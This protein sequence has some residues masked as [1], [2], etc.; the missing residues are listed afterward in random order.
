MKSIMPELIGNR[1]LAA[2]IGQEIIS[3][4]LS[5]AYIIGGAKGSGRHTLANLIAASLACENKDRDDLPLPC[6]RC[7]HCRKIFSKISP[8]VI[9]YGLEDKAS[10]GVETVRRLRTDI[11][12]PP[13]DLHVKVYIIEDAD[14]M[15]HQAQNA[16][17][18]TLEEPPQYVL[19]LLLCERPEDMLETVRSRAPIL[20]TE[21][22]SAEEIEKY[23]VGDEAI[24]SLRK[25]SPNEFFEIVMASDGRIGKALELASPEHRSEILAA[26]AHA[27]NFIEAVAGRP[28]ASTLISLV[29][30][31]PKARADISVRINLIT[32]A[33]RDLIVLKRSE[34]A[35]L[36]FYHDRDAAID[37]SDR[38]TLSGLLSLYRACED[39]RKAILKNSNVKLTLT[40]LVI[41]GNHGK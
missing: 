8:D 10:I 13:N 3:G 40:N 15:T 11:L 27:K 38:F 14:K 29:D 22:L 34:D 26:R 35:P 33:L 31:F 16:F 9:V 4:G 12:T 20:R 30:E 23:L 1:A 5:H 28:D 17:L 25:N 36:C 37:V 19:F 18:L 7:E 6:H 32:S 2:K 21:P 24:E 41:R 39:A